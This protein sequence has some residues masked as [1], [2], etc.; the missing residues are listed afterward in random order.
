MKGGQMNAFP[1]KTTD[2]TVT[3]GNCQ[4]FKA[5]PSQDDLLA[6]FIH[7]LSD[8]DEVSRWKAAE[9]LGRRKTRQQWRT[10]SV[11]SGMTTP[12]SGSRLHGHSAG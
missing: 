10:S 2:H 12:A 7:M 5:G 4:L 3:A 1:L 6:H 11:P 8:D 9:A